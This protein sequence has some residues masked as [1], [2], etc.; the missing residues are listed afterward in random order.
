[1]DRII[2][3]GLRLRAYHGVNE[4][5]KRCGQIFYLDII[6]HTDLDRASR[7]DRLE[8]T[9]NYSAVIKTASAAFCSASFDLIERAAGYT[10]DSILEAFP[11]VRSVDITVRKPDAPVSADI[12]YAAVGLT[13]ERADK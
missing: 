12:E 10:A 5:E 6:L 2:I 7:T 8:D 13:R 9:V 11:A 1:M 3:S 4:D